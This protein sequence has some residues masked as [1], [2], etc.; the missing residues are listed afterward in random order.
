GARHLVVGHVL[1]SPGDDAVGVDGGPGAGYDEGHAHLA[2]ALVG[3]SN[4]G[5][6]GEALVAEEQ[7]LD[8]GRVGVDPA[9]DEHVF[10]PVGDPDVAPVV[11]DRDVTG[12]QPAVGVD[13]GFG[14]LGLLE[15]AAHDVVAAYDHF[16]GFAARD[17]VPSGIDHA[18]LGV[19]NG[20]SGPV[21]DRVGGVIVAAHRRGAGRLGESV[22]GDDRLEGHL[23]AQT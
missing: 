10:L 22:A 7:V 17:L 6:L 21:G 13:R 19:G 16:A 3:D 8:L 23:V 14:L 4:H 18:E 2:E 11:H 12:V 5:H 1:A 15:V 20:S 9:D